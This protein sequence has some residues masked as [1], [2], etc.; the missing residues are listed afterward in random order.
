MGKSMDTFYMKHLQSNIIR[1]TATHV[2]Q[3]G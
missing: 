1:M 2:P 3:A